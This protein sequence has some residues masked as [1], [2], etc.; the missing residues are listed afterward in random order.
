VGEIFVAG[1][2]GGGEAVDVGEIEVG[3]EFGGVARE[4]ESEDN[5][6]LETGRRKLEWGGGGGERK[7][8]QH[9]APL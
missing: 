2:E 7:R 3:F 4:G 6:K 5:C 9:A 8:A 1:G